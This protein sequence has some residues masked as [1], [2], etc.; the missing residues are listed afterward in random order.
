MKIL[1]NQFQFSILLAKLMPFYSG[2]FIGVSGE[3][4]PFFSKKSDE[5]KLKNLHKIKQKKKLSKK[6]F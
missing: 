3:E 2:K 5:R 6:T 1:S 4:I